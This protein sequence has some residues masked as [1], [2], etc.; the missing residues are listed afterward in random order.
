[1]KKILAG[2]V[3]VTSILFSS[4]PQVYAV[5][6]NGYY[7]SNGT[8]VNGYERTAPDSSPYNNYSYPGNY[9]PNTGNITGGNADTYLN[10]YYNNSSGSTYSP[11]YNTYDYTPVTTCPLNSYS[12]GSGSCKCNYGY[13]VS[14]GSCVSQD[15]LCH[16]QTG[17]ASSYNSLNNTCECDYGYVLGSS[18]QCKMASLICSDQI[19]LMSQYNSSTKKCECMSGY[20]F[21]GSSCEYKSSNYSYSSTN[22]ANQSSCPLNSHDSA[23]SIGKCDCDTGYQVNSAKNACV[24]SPIKTNIEI[25]QDSFGPNTN[26]DGTKT[27][28]GQLN[29]TCNSG[30]KF[31]GTPKKCV[32][33]PEIKKVVEDIKPAIIE[34][35]FEVKDS[36]ILPLIATGTLK[37]SAKFRKCPSTNCSIIR[38]YAET[39][40]L[41]ITGTTMSGDWYRIEGST[42]AGGS[43]TKIIGWVSKSVFDY[44]SINKNSTEDLS[45]I[46]SSTTNIDNNPPKIEVSKQGWF[47]KLINWFK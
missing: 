1:M 8:Y 20:E 31:N 7:R 22:L 41:F 10:N 13:A 4:I 19:G 11:T 21:N 25:C 39:S 27:N 15:T 47:D 16:N 36:D 6:V 24:L 34:S 14:G 3:I 38:Y 17:Y 2:L 45:N 23:T 5:H 33:I 12:N 32:I 37:I 46:I 9:N 42:D 40:D 44:I 35:N 29:C 43:G 30:Y 26:W 28:D 18:G